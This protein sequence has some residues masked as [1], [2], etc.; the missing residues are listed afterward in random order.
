METKEGMEPP[1][2]CKRLATLF[3]LLAVA[4]V[5]IAQ[6]PDLRKLT[7]A[8]RQFY[9]SGQRGAEWLQRANRPDGRFVFG[10]VPA[11]RTSLE[12][13]DYLA[14]AGAALA[15]A[16]ASH[17]FADE[18]SAAI[19]RQALLTLLLDTI[20]DPQD[21]SLRYTRLP[22]ELLDRVAAAGMLVSAIHELPDPG[23]DLLEQSNGLC[24]Y[25][26][27]QQKSDG[28]LSSPASRSGEA[29]SGVA[30]YGLLRSQ[31]HL[32]ASWKMDSVHKARQYYMAGWHKQKSLDFITWHSAAY[33]EAYLQTKE[34]AFADSVFEMNDWLCTLQYDRFNLPNPLW[35][36]GFKHWQEGREALTAPDMDSARCALSLAQACRTARQAGDVP[37]WQRYRAAL[38]MCLHFVS[39]LQYNEGNT[40]HFVPEYRPVLVGAFHPSHQNGD[41]R[42]DCTQQAVAALTHYCKHLAHDE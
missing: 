7:L 1:R 30:L 5:S 41:L 22:S 17:T 31:Q 27:S 26:R 15:L 28:S 21:A 39:T 11:L 36:G 20:N 4:G 9:L 23:K 42:L 8:Q 2:M 10:H 29:Y 3:A 14:Q 35:L 6:G 32:P 40:Q 24:L 18:R 25:L 12:G 37:R 19:A 38:E 13:N 33:T 16:R 34:R